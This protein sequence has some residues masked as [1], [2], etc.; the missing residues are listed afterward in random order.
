MPAYNEPPT[1]AEMEA[2]TAH[3]EDLEL[4]PF[5]GNKPEADSE[6]KELGSENYIWCFTCGF[7]FEGGTW[8]DLFERW[9]R[10]EW[11]SKCGLKKRGDDSEAS[12]ALMDV[13]GHRCA[14]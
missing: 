8:D 10:R 4:C 1:T 13:M 5:C 7:G 2:M 12:E 14:C 9:N 6:D 11:C 3:D